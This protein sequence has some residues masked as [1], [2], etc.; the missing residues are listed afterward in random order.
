MQN[1]IYYI[2]ISNIT[3]KLQKKN[4]YKSWLF[5]PGHCTIL[6]MTI[7]NVELMPYPE[8]NLIIHVKIFFQLAFNVYL[9]SQQPSVNPTV[10]DLTPLCPRARFLV[11]KE[12]LAHSSGWQTNPAST[13]G[14]QR[15]GCLLHG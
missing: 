7:E 2:I 9:D 5:I 3:F 11:G 1:T 14:V 10:G 6:H 13:E 12:C 8:S 4:K 15:S